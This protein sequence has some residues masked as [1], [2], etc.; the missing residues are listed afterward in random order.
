M[1]YRTASFAD[2]GFSSEEDHLTAQREQIQHTMLTT[3]PDDM[4]DT[5]L[6]LANICETRL[7]ETQ[8]TPLGQWYEAFGAML[9]VVLANAAADKHGPKPQSLLEDPLLY[10]PDVDY[11]H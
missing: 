1:E 3:S 4:L 10:F 2:H 9:R 5:V 8:D 7:L 11:M 6:V